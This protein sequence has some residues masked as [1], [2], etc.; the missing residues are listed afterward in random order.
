MQVDPI[1]AYGV[2]VSNHMHT[3][4][5]MQPSSTVKPVQLRGTTPG[6]Q[7][8][9]PNLAG[10][11]GQETLGAMPD[12]SL[13]WMPALKSSNLPAPGWINPS[14][15]LVYYRN[16]GVDPDDIV[17]FDQNFSFRAGDPGATK[18][19]KSLKMEWSC[20][21]NKDDINDDN[22]V[23]F[24][25]VIPPTC[26]M[27]FDGDPLKPYALRLVVYFP[28]CI[29]RSS[30]STDQQTGQWT[31]TR[32]T[33]AE[34]NPEPPEEPYNWECV[35]EPGVANYDAIPQV[36]IGFRWP[37]GAASGVLPHQSLPTEWDLSSL[38]L[39]SDDGKT[40]GITGHADFMS[41]WSTAQ[42]ATFMRVCFWSPQATPSNR[43]G[44]QNCGA[45]NDSLGPFWGQN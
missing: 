2:P 25:Q 9:S 13:Y 6:S 40:P 10:K 30:G 8:I 12:K 16:A 1:G 15:V 18:P 44:P 11:A 5:N 41:G 37:L 27:Y 21:A 39:S 45:I 29:D 19:Q 35:D 33:W 3:F 43:Y 32:Y 24:D 38:S 36:Q 23:N 26:P 20:V 28:N 4:S 14:D 31:P 7:C 42:L 17:A 34:F 22:E